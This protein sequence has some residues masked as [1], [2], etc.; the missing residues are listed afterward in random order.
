MLQF[1]GRPAGIF[2]SL[3]FPRAGMALDCSLRHRRQHGISKTLM[4]TAFSTDTLQ[5]VASMQKYD[6]AV[7]RI[8]NI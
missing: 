4:P 3:R 6:S 1:E 7:W 2:A 8:S 5:G